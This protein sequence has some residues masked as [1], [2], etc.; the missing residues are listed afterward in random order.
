[1]HPRVQNIYS[2]LCIR[3]RHVLLFLL[4]HVQKAASWFLHLQDLFF[5]PLTVFYGFNLDA[6]AV[7]HNLA[8]AP[9]LQPPPPLRAK[10]FLLKR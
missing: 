5:V 7:T 4:L 2:P 1:M 9:G 8:G 6:P 10:L 3:S